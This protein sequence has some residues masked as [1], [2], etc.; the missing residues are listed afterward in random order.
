MLNVDLNALHRS[1]VS[2]WVPL[3]S[4][5]LV[6]TGCA[7]IGGGTVEA[8][9]T[10]N[11]E[12]VLDPERLYELRTTDPEKMSAATRDYGVRIE[13][14]AEQI[15]ADCM[16]RRGL[17]YVPATEDQIHA[18]ANALGARLTPEAAKVDGYGISIT[19]P[20]GDD[21]SYD[22]Y[23]TKEQVDA[24]LAPGGCGEEG[25]SI[26][27]QID[28]VF[29]RFEPQLAELMSAFVS[30]SRVVAAEGEWTHC[31]TEA[32]FA[33][34]RSTHELQNSIAAELDAS[35][36]AAD[37]R[38]LQAH[39]RSAAAADAGCSATADL[40]RSDVLDALFEAF[41]SKFRAEIIQELSEVEMN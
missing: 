8:T 21:D 32:G 36:G 40:V 14:K 33:G 38:R 31:M 1:V 19:A 28:E 15:V 11:L 13:L 3:V 39:E 9:P 27:R 12:L 18:R 16:N 2:L 17:Q 22:P 20:G 4:I 25:R 41:D 26:D 7:E 24:L 37:L 23:A 35:R 5:G 29:E 10:E 30:D 6:A 34:F